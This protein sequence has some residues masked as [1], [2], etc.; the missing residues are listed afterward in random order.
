MSGEIVST[1]SLRRRTRV[2]LAALVVSAAL[3]AP[4]PAGPGA[5]ATTS[6]ASGCSSVTVPA[7]F[8]PGPVWDRTTSGSP[9]IGRTLIVN[10]ASGPG[11]EPDA[12]Y[13]ATVQGVR[14]A[15][16]RVVGYVHTSYGA[17]PVDAVLADIERYREWYGVVDVFLDEVSSSAGDL[18]YYRPVAEHIRAAEGQV[19]LN[20]GTHPDERYMALGDQVVTFEGTYDTYR[21]IQVPAWT[22]AYPPGRFTHLVYSTSKRQLSTALSLASQ[23]RAGNVYVTNDGGTNPWDTLPP[24]WADEI[25]SL[26]SRC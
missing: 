14:M 12:N 3:V 8:Y 21:R 26:A 17:R 1:S 4:V 7:Y 18:E 23:R 15:G 24:Y 11:T 13:V 16:A 19:L 10:P 25:S 6:S 9:T 22:A 20:P 2:P 5:A